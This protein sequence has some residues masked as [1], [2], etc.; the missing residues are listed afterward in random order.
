MLAYVA[1]GD[2]AR[3]LPMLNASEKDF[4]AD[5]N[6]P[7]RIARVSL[8]LHKL[9]DAQ[10]AALRALA[11]GYGPRKLKLYLL[12][13]DILKAKGDA[14]GVS[15]VVDEALAYAHGLP[16]A[17]VPAAV[18]LDLEKRRSSATP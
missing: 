8:E 7:A 3:A 9:D 2:P 14:P 10:A 11:R 18:V 6:P 17:D 16:K 5:Y 1:L 4:P 12:L 13:A 15:R